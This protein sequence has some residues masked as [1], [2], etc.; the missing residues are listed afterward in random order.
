M[1]KE[2]KRLSYVSEL[3]NVTFVQQHLWN[4]TSTLFEHKDRSI[5]FLKWVMSNTCILYVIDLFNK[6]NGEFKTLLELSNDL[7]KK[8]VWFCEYT[9]WKK[10]TKKKREC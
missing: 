1:H 5:Y 2:C 6:K 4:N 10:I 3:P 8:N 7:K 9:I